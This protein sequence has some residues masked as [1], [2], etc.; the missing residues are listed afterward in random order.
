VDY[1]NLLKEKEKLRSEVIC[2]TDKLHAKEKGLEIQT[3]DLETTCK[4]AFIQS[5]SQFESLEKSGIVS[6]GMTAPFD[7]QLVSYSIEDPLSSGTDGS[8][9]VDEESPHHIDS[10][11]SS[12]VGYVTSTHI[13]PFEADLSDFSHVDEEEEEG[14][15]EKLLLPQ[16]CHM[17][18]ECILFPEA[19]TTSC[20]YVFAMDDQEN[21]SWWDWP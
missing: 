20:T 15:S 4:K 7:Q 17:K 13:S 2:L 6:K 5:N 18:M 21:L 19:P 14:I 3:N 12:V 11:H 16:D 9:V 1:D 8:A 10:G